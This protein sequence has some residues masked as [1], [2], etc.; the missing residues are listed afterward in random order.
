MKHIRPKLKSG[1]HGHRLWTFEVIEFGAQFWKA[2]DTLSIK[3]IVPHQLRHSGPSIE[4]SK[5]S[6][7]LDANNG[8]REM[9]KRQNKDA[10]RKARAIGTGVSV[11]QRHADRVLRAVRKICSGVILWRAAPMVAPPQSKVKWWWRSVKV[12]D[13]V[14]RACE[15]RGLK[16][17]TWVPDGFATAQ[18]LLLTLRHLVR[19]QRQ[20]AVVI[21]FQHRILV[22]LLNSRV[23]QCQRVVGLAVSQRFPVLVSLPSASPL[24]H[25]LHHELNSMESV[26]TLR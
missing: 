10:I 5:T 15:D 2:A 17:K 1:T 3:D 23:S 21:N 14:A 22:E 26:H 12:M 9:A 7:N 6:R 25:R 18:A 4:I 24:S 13:R 16:A 19:K 20:Q 11:V 8:R